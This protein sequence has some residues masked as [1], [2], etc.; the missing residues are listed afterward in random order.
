MNSIHNLIIGSPIIITQG[1]MEFPYS[2]K[3]QGISCFEQGNEVVLRELIKHLLL[4]VYLSSQ[5]PE[6]GSVHSAIKMY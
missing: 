5:Y 6:V 1:L 3:C 4:T 2:Q